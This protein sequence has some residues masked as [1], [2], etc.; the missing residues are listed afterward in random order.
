M[1]ENLSPLEELKLKKAFL[2]AQIAGIDKEIAR[3]TPKPIQG[4]SDAL[5]EYDPR[6]IGLA[7][8]A[9][10]LHCDLRCNH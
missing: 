3:L 1:K 5:G 9:E 6:T 4:G 7:R 2:T 8:K 10:K